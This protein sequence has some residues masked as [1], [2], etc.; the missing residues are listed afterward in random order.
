MLQVRLHIAADPQ[1][2]RVNTIYRCAPL[3]GSQQGAVSAL[4]QLGTL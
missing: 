1:V 4:V 2:A 3:E